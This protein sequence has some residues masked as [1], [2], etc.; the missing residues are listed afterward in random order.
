LPTGSTSPALEGHFERDRSGDVA[1]REIAV[2]LPASGTHLADPLTSVGDA[3][4]SLDLEEVERPE[5]SVRRSLPVSRSAVSI[6]VSTE[7][8]SGW[9]PTVMLPLTDGRRPRVVETTR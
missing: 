4:E 7:L 8:S 2:D 9:S 5:V 1:D 3:R 6:D